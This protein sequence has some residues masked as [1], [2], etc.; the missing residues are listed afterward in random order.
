M[1]L[2]AGEGGKG[3]GLR[4][5]RARLA[6]L[7]EVAR[8]V[9]ETDDHDRLL[10]VAVKAA[11][12]TFAATHVALFSVLPD[13][14]RLVAYDGRGSEAVKVGREQPIRGGILGEVLRTGEPY[15]A[16]DVAADPHYLPG[17]EDAAAEFSCPV[18]V[19]GRLVAVLDV[20]SGNKDA[21]SKDDVAV[22]CLLAAQIGAAMRHAAT[23]GQSRRRREE[24]ETILDISRRT[25]ESLETAEVLGLVAKAI[26]QKLGYHYVLIFLR[27]DDTG[28]LVLRATAGGTGKHLELGFVLPEG[29]GLTGWVATHGEAVRVP[30]VAAD[31]RYLDAIPESRSCLVLPVP[32]E[33]GVVG[34][35]TVESQRADDFD[36]FD[37]RVLATLAEE[38]GKAVQNARDHRDVRHARDR[39]GRIAGFFRSVASSL[40]PDGIIEVVAKEVPGICGVERLGVFLL[41]EG[42]K[43]L[44]LHSHSQVS[45]LPENLEL[46][47]DGGSLL[48][49]CVR[50]GEDRVVQDLAAELGWEIRPGFRTGAFAVL[51]MRSG[52]K[53]MGVLTAA[54]PV[55]ATRFS[56]EQINLLGG[57]AG[58]IATA[59][60]NALQFEHTVR[61]SQTDDLTGLWSRRYFEPALRRELARSKRL[62]SPLTVMMLDLDHF[63][64]INDTHGHG[65][66]DEVLKEVA[67]RAQEVV[68]Q[69]DVVGRFGGEEF[70][71]ILPDT[72]AEPAALA[73]ERLRAAV[74]AEAI[75]TSAGDI[76]VT[77]SLGVA[78][79]PPLEVA[80]PDDLVALADKALYRAKEAGRNRLE[81]AAG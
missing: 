68:R 65:V 70:L 45:D 69:V 73:G 52:D 15:L 11:R 19:E 2:V 78:S 39:M 5:L 18:F 20:E 22:L 50:G 43:V 24:V 28:K 80:F 3:G 63:K 75:A 46:A 71:V 79:T 61:L 40:S 9:G 7:G 4:A 57:L 38:V 47:H 62:G 56:G 77:V 23:L 42:R 31:K 72:A 27:D 44:R 36:D 8:G 41:D 66:G 81:A 26:E 74:A 12:E 59:L 49:E 58:Q 33:G 35:I 60:S 10:Q 34:T 32:G 13:C 17:Y 29:Q 54:D 30:D 53:A 67:R 21:F 48:W 55:G 14:L 76:P 16:N 6:L 37:I 64:R 51:P 25:L 1:R